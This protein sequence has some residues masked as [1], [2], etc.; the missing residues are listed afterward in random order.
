MR[1][2]KTRLA[3]A[4]AVAGLVAVA[5]GGGDD[6]DAAAGGQ[7]EDAAGTTGA[8]PTDGGG[9]GPSGEPIVVG[10]SL[11]LSGFLAPTAIIHKVA[12]ELFV[13]R[14]NESGGLLGRPVEW[15]VLDDE[16][17]P[18]RAAA[19]YERLITEEQ[20]DAV[21]GPYGTGTIAAAMPVAQRHGFVFPQHTGSLTY[22]FGYECQFPTWATGR[23]PNLTTIDT[24]LDA[25]ESTGTPPETLAFVTNEFPGSLFMAHGQPD[26]Q[27]DDAIGAVGVSEE[28]GYEIVLDITF[29]TNISDWG[30][31]AAQIRDADPDFV[32]VPGIG[33]DGPNL[34]QAMQQLNY[35]PPGMFVLWPAPG[36]LLAAGGVGSGVT[37][38][39]TFE[40]GNGPLADEPEVQE[41]AQAFNDAAEA[42]GIPFTVFETQAAASWTAWEILVSGIEGA[43]TVEQE[44]VCDHLR[45]NG[46][47]TTLYGDLSFD[48]ANNNYYGDLQKIKQVQ[49]GEWVVVWPED[50]RNEGVEVRYSPDAA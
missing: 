20:V 40:Q 45:E 25:L 26:A 31:I 4:L 24:L 36:P 7:T 46:A 32:I 2:S 1:T 44:A 9:G 34:I 17:A 43:G 27:G 23:Q 30:P 15:T 28:R 39:T 41:I 37:S 50:A 47:Q 38:V 16:S 19:L 48:P 12:G 13:E 14:L 21:I 29:P 6:G 10:G 49:D 11:A 22:A 42:E 35:E 3:A 5:C 18:D 8:E 33:L